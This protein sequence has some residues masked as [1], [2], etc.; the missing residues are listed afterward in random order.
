MDNAGRF[1]DAL[2]QAVK[3]GKTT[4]PELGA[5]LANV[6]GTAATLNVP[7]ETLLASVST[8]TA[9]GMPTSQAVTAINAALSAMLAPS[10]QA[11]KTADALGLEF[12]AAAVKSKGFEVVLQE[13]AKATGGNEDLMKKLFGS[14][15]ALKAVLPLT[16]AAAE[17]FSASLKNQADNAGAATEAFAKMADASTLGSQ[18]VANAIKTMLIAIGTPLLDEFGGIQQAIAAIFNAIGRSIDSGAMSGFVRQIEDLAAKIGDT[19]N[20]VARNLPAALESADFSG[21]FRGMRDVQD[22][23]TR[24]FDGA[25]ITTAEGLAEV[26]GKVGMGFETLSRFTA[27]A[28]D[29][30]KPFAA[31]ALELAETIASLDPEFV[32]TAA[33]VGIF[34]IALTTV[35]PV[36]NTILTMIGA[37]A[38]AGGALPLLTKAITG[39]AGVVAG[40]TGL[41]VA[42]GAAGYGLGTL[43]N[44]GVNAL[45][46]KLTGADSLGAL[47]YD[48]THNT[49]DLT[50][51]TKETTAALKQSAAAVDTEAERIARNNDAKISAAIAARE[52]IEATE[53]YTAAFRSMGLIL[54]PVTGD[55]KQATKAIDDNAEAAIAAR[56]AYYELQGTTPELARRMAEMEAPIKKV[57]AVMKETEKQSEA[58]A[59]KILE[60]TSNE[61]MKTLELHV[62]MRV[63]QVENETKRI[64]KSFESL[65]V[66]IQS[67]GDLI[68]SLFGNLTSATSFQDKWSIQRQIDSE[69]K[70]RQQEFDLQKKLTEEQIKSMEARRRAVERGDAL[71]QIDGAGLQPH[72][73]SFMFEILRAIQVRVAGE[74]GDL[75][76]GLPE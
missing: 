44:D 33:K 48:L 74:G 56:A 53:H 28:I 26:I 54:D 68:G 38:G 63:A 72:L 46:K 10:E 60:L 13:V 2:F 9:V 24:L 6:T 35:I 31:V 59:M 15:E 69:D 51:A 16:G 17:K 75:L 49:E 41:V 40:P 4:L 42:A 37:L 47:I 8:L 27:A 50:G 71:I 1:S 29:A 39:V 73:E 3:D 67:T 5:A 11:Q 18:A 58:L 61:K 34:A 14:T 21:F 64:E 20:A 25:D 55:V 57:G 65:N 32:A 70:R 36:V 23:I 62:N 76:L 12:N 30:V 45:T 43:L 19:L 66:G 7:F 22:A 52:A